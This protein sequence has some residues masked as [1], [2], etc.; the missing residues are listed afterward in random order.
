[1]LFGTRLVVILFSVMFI[2]SDIFAAGSYEWPQ[3]RGAN[4]DGLSK[5]TGLLKQWPS[6]SPVQVWKISDLGVG[7]SGFS[8][9]KGKMFTM[10]D[11]DGGCHLIALDEFTGKKLW[12]TKIGETGQYGGYEGPRGTPTVDGNCVYALNQHGDLVCVDSAV[13][14]EIWRK[15]LTKDFGGRIP[16]WGYA[17]SPLVDGDKVIVTPGGGQGAIVALNKKTGDKIWQTKDFTDPAHYS[18]MIIE[19]VLGQRQVIQF[20]PA[21]VVGVSV[22]DGKVLW[23]GD[24][25]GKVA[26]VPTP[27]YAD[28]QVFVCSAYGV[29]CNAFKIVKEGTS[30]KAEQL[31]ANKNMVNHHG[32]VILLN[33]YLY[34]HCDGKGWVCQDF[35]TGEIA[36][37]NKG[38]GKGAI[39]YADGHFYIRSETGDGPV[40]LI[41]ANPREYVEKGR[42]SQPDRSNKK[43]WTHPVILNGK[44]YIRD[45]GILLCYDIKQK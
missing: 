43:S 19:N 22:S 36:W 37:V 41:E 33:G 6:G 32:G 26:V 12:S 13:G 30:F 11:L 14:R 10:G 2:V 7:Y 8:A 18:S 9:V 27:I 1:M 16:S 25:P 24:R 15:S 4:R 17:E 45:Q 29:G 23:R 35:K 44:L 42:F 5:E 40:A 34:G 39:S 28:N 20:T 38:V 31:Y 21:S 3:W